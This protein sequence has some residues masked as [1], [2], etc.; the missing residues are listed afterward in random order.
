MYLNPES[1]FE[2]KS[3]L[4]S[5]DYIMWSW[6]GVSLSVLIIILL[7]LQRKVRMTEKWTGSHQLQSHCLYMPLVLSIKDLDNYFQH[8]T[9]SVWIHV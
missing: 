8:E 6:K 7:K 5:L 3:I 4:T 1:D 9:W 2:F